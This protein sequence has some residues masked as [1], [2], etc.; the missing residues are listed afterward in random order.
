[1]NR[2]RLFQFITALALLLNSHYSLAVLSTPSISFPSANATNI[3]NKVTITANGVSGAFYYL[4]EVDSIATFK[5]SY[6]K[7]YKVSTNSIL[8]DSLPFNQNH[9][10]RIKV[11]NAAQSD[12][13]AWRG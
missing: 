8:L 12:S 4:F 3:N 5:S 10:V 13:S 6:Y 7:K 11:F 1:M 2:V 9:F